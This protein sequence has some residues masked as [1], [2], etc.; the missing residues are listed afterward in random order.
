MRGNCYLGAGGGNK[1]KIGHRERFSL[2]STTRM[3]TGSDACKQP[4]V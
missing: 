3:R 2:D 4:T 1:G